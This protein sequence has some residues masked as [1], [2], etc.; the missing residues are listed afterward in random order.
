MFT[1][2]LIGS[3]VGFSGAA[4]GSVGGVGGGGN[5]CLDHWFDPKSSTAISKYRTEVLYAI[6]LVMQPMLMLG[7]SIGVAFNVMFANWMVTVLLIILFL[8]TA[9]KALMKGIET[10]KKETMMKKEAEKK[11]E[12]ESKPFEIVLSCADGSGEDYKLLP[13]GPASLPD[14]QVPISHNDDNVY[15]K[16]LLMIVYVWV[17]FLIVQI[18]K[19][20]LR[21]LKPNSY[22]KDQG[23]CVQRKGNH[24]LEVA[25]DFSVLQLWDS[26]WYSSTQDK[27][28]SILF[29]SQK[30]LSR[31][32]WQGKITEEVWIQ[33]SLIIG[34]DPKSSTAISKSN[35][36]AGHQH[37]SGLQRHVRRLDGYSST[38]YSLLR[39]SSKS[40]NKGNRNME[41]R[42]N[43][44]EESRKAVGI[45]VQTWRFLRL[46]YCIC[47]EERT[48]DVDGWLD[49]WKAAL[50]KDLEQQ[51]SAHLLH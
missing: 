49:A 36:H 41:E 11:L 43:D 50:P 44:E 14:E 30:I 8:V 9:A 7:I 40:F 17:A 1:V 20:P 37:R 26:S 12:S 42:D 34:F 39:Y 13:S 32:P 5:A 18:V 21:S 19:S 48:Y 47:E 27:I 46:N 4:L 29:V 45:R 15:W 2:V 28:H 51:K 10:W 24:K 31:N 35:A 23:D 6:L 25:S 38:Y 16:E 3:I 22:A 33:N